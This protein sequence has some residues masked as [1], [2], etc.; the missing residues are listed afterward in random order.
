[1]K[2]ASPVD[3]VV[4]ATGLRHWQVLAVAAAFAPALRVEVLG[5]AGVVVGLQAQTLRRV[6]P[7]ISQ[8]HLALPGTLVQHDELVLLPVASFGV[9]RALWRLH[10]A[11]VGET[12]VLAAAGLGRGVGLAV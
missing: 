11:D 7:R 9:R 1:M 2:A 10:P 3:D 12:S 4:E 5:V 6:K 8:P